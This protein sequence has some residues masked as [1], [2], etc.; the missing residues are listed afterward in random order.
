MGSKNNRQV[1]AGQ[2][3]VDS[4]EQRLLWFQWIKENHKGPSPFAPCPCPWQ[5]VQSLPVVLTPA[6]DGVHFLQEPAPELAALRVTASHI[7]EKNVSVPR[8]AAVMTGVGGR[9]L[10]IQFTLNRPPSGTFD[11]GISVLRTGPHVAS[12]HYEEVFVGVQSVTSGVSSIIY[13]DASNSSSP[14]MVSRVQQQIKLAPGEPVD[15]RVFLDHSVVEV[16]GAQGAVALTNRAYPTQAGY[17]SAALYSHGD[18]VCTFKVAEAWAL[19][20][21]NMSTVKIN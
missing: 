15:V 16:F 4:A 8:G 10:E 7:V 21:I 2:I 11:C 14:K 17:P 6:S 3:L 13:I 12:G 19:R 5:G 9:Q 18:Q 1:Y 20:S